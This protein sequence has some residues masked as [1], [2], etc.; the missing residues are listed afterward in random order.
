VAKIIVLMGAPGVGK[1]TQARL[2]SQRFGWPHI[3]TGDILRE[4]A[5]TDT[6]LGRHVKE[7][8]AA[9]FLVSDEILA[10]IIEERTSR[11][12]CQ[13]GYILDGFPRTINQ[14]QLLDRLAM[15][16]RNNMVV[17]NLPVER[18]TVI[19]R[20]SGR[21]TCPNCGQI[22]NV[23]FQPPAREGV[24][25]KCQTPLMS[26]SD[27]AP[28]AVAKRLD[29]YEEKTAPLIEFYH[30]AGRLVEVDGRRSVEDIFDEILQ[31]LDQG[32]H[33]HAAHQGRD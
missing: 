14:A 6:E 32:K 10:Q 22:Y 19:K 15:E 1:G 2:L 7:V 5:A 20:L 3:S 29:V 16:Q 28:E 17:I 30:N 13:Q 26:R 21:R 33:D 27:D 9:G 4:I 23:Y 25:D 11:Q 31:I 24:C 8:Q 12:D 18:E